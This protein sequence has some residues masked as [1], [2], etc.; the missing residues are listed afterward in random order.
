MIAHTSISND[1]IDLNEVVVQPSLKN[2]E[3]HPRLELDCK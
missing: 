3:R 1:S 2:D